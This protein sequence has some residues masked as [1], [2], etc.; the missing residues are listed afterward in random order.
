MGTGSLSWQDPRKLR[1][2]KE[3]L[4]EPI[5]RRGSG[6]RREDRQQSRQGPRWRLVLGLRSQAPQ[7]TENP[8]APPQ[9][10]SQFPSRHGRSGDTTQLWGPQRVGEQTAICKVGQEPS[11]MCPGHS[12]SQMPLENRRLPLAL[13]PVGAASETAPEGLSTRRHSR[14][15]PLGIW[16][17]TSCLSPGNPARPPRLLTSQRQTFLS[18]P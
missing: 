17:P 1:T 3:T 4:A 11:L 6:V 9:P 13:T 16:L 14:P 2:C 15:A 8:V 7:V 10:C 12:E 18:F 5:T